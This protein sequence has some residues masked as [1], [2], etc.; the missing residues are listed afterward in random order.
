MPI[1]AQ[2]L[3]L[4]TIGTHSADDVPSAACILPSALTALSHP[5]TLSATLLMLSTVQPY[6]ADGRPVRE[7]G[8]WEMHLAAHTESLPRPGS[9]ENGC[10][11]VNT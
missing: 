9:A 3:L 11:V 10:K 8:K 4:A 2:P 5:A 7:E 1:N 6:L